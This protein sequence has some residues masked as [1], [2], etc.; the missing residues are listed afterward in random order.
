MKK[1]SK[2][3]PDAPKRLWI[4]PYHLEHETGLMS[5]GDISY[6]E[7]W[8]GHKNKLPEDRIPRNEEEEEYISLSQ[9]WH[10]AKE[11]PQDMF[12]YIIVANKDFSIALTVNL[13]TECLHGILD[14]TPDKVKWNKIIRK[15]LKFAYWTYLKDIIPTKFK[16]GGVK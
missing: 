8:V 9:S 10:E 13:A 15:N 7:Y 14:D 4:R 5:I 2:I 6:E 11:V 3:I 12:A 16:K 1:D